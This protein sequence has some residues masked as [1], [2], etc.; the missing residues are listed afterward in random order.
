[1]YKFKTEMHCHTLESSKCGKI[2]AK[3]IVEAYIDEGYNTLVITDHFGSRHKSDEGINHDIHRLINGC[4]AAKE[5]SNGRINIIFG[6]EINFSENKNDY[7]VYGLTED[8]LLNN[9]DI[10][11]LGIK[12]F[13]DI[14]HENGLLIYQAHPFRNNMTITSPLLLDGIEV[15]NAHPRHDSRNSISK[16]WAEIY[17]LREISGSDVHQPQD[18]ARGGIMTTNEIKTT[19]DLLKVLIENDYKLITV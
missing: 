19:D 16:N 11:N 4:N 12:E 13:S 18:I 1:M 10:Y 2:Q 6:V 8:F 7:L 9:P 3:D 14:A 17:N 5:A 15:F